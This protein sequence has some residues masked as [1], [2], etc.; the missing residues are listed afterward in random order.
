MPNYIDLAIFHSPLSFDA[1]TLEIWGALL[2]GGCCII[3]QEEMLTP[4]TLQRVIHL[5]GVN[6]LWV[7]R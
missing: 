1:A 6:T 5:Y 3:H 7:C 4:Q 2:N